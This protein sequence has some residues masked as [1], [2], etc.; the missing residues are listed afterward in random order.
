ML[1]AKYWV[2]S[3]LL[4]IILNLMSFIGHYISQALMIVFDPSEEWILY[5]FSS[6]V[7]TLF[8]NFTILL[9]IVFS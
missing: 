1:K 5:Y 4:S 3:V 7:A 6:L 2:T 8:V 9:L